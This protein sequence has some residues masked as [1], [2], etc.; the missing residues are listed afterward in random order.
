MLRGATARREAR[1]W[2]PSQV[3]RRGWSVLARRADV[4]ERGRTGRTTDTKASEYPRKPGIYS[5]AIALQGAHTDQQ[6]F[7]VPLASDLRR[8]EARAS[9]KGGERQFTP[10]VH[11][12]SPGPVNY[13]SHKE[14][15]IEESQ[16]EENHRRAGLGMNSDSPKENQKRGEHDPVHSG[17]P[18][19]SQGDYAS[20]T[21]SA[22]ER[23]KSARAAFNFG[24][25]RR[26]TCCDDA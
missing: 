3:R 15:H 26:Y 1:V 11:R 6:F 16:A 10:P 22:R 12:S 23:L 13:G 2:S 5:E 7:C 25:L 8:L 20:L 21:A 24:D 19:E 17:S 14:S 18:K 9:A 4:G